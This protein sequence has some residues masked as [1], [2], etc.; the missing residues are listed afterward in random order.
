[1]KDLSGFRNF[2]SA[3]KSLIGLSVT[4]PYKKAVMDFLDEVDPVAE[5]IGAV[6]CIKINLTNNGLFIKGYNTDAFGFETSLK[7]L[8]KPNHNKALILGTGGASLAI[9]YVLAKM[10]IEYTFVSRNPSD[11]KHIRY[12]KLNRQ[13]MRDF[14]II[15]NTTPVGMFPNVEEKP[16]IPYENLSPSHLLYDL[17][18]NPQ[19]TSF[20]KMG[21]Q[22]GAIVKNGYD[23]LTFQAEKAWEIWNDK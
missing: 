14:K 3:Q 15:I 22:A 6:N 16:C 1:M 2:I 10:E 13:M 21:Q 12:E 17:T 11:C 8:L 4:I 7:P 23:M 9:A 18:Y 20:M 5:K 19:I